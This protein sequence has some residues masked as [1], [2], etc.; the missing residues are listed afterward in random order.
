VTALPVTAGETLAD[1]PGLRVVLL[2]ETGA[3]AVS[4]SVATAGSGPFPPLHVHGR[5]A[6]C[7]FVLDGAVTVDL[8]G[9]TR[10][11]EAES[12]IQVPKG[13]AH[14]FAPAGEGP[15]TFVNVHAPSCGYG[16]FIRGLTAATDEEGLQRARE[17]FDLLAPD[18][19]SD[20][21]SAAVVHRLGGSEGEAI[22]ERAGRRVTLLGDSEEAGVTESVYG[23]GERG[24]DLHVH[25]EHTDVW[26]VLE[27]T[28]AFTLGTES[29][30]EAG[31]GTLVVVPPDIAH[32]FANESAAPARYVNLHVPSCGFGDYL[33]GRHPGFDQHDPPADGGADP[34]GVLVRRLP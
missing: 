30:L 15:A 7:F 20:D 31:A 18:Q 33:R 8:G 23:P 25:H 26:I 5:H 28:L 14:T 1:R 22:T 17:G 12:W 27:G 16:T 10:V 11:V 4:H 19:A 3:I 29:R 2:A 34:A 13:V 6:D 21:A 9:A 32:S 24:P